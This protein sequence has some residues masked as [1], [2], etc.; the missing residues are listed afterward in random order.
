MQYT[1]SCTGAASDV[2]KSAH[3]VDNKRA[4]K[5]SRADKLGDVDDEDYTEDELEDSDESPLKGGL[6]PTRKQKTSSLGPVEEEDEEVP[7]SWNIDVKGAKYQRLKEVS[8]F[9][10]RHTCKLSSVTT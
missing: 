9:L 10:S 8:M 1:L 3:L 4:R 7:S 5:R 6:V 2:Q